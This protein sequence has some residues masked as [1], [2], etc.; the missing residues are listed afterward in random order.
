MLLSG[1]APLSA[2]TQQFMNICFCCPIGQGYGLTET[3]GAGSIHDG[4]Y[5]D[6]GVLSSYLNPYRFTTVSSYCVTLL[7]S[8]W[9]FI[10][11]NSKY[12]I[13]SVIFCWDLDVS[14]GSPGRISDVALG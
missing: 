11:A 1:G 14:K 5:N 4:T 2:D 13:H 6:V 9:Q 10:R 7:V 8:R 12:H 3:C